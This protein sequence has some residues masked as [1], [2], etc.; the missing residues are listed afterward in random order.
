M[1]E[2]KPIGTVLVG[3]ISRSSAGDLCGIFIVTFIS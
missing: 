1:A 3:K 2:K